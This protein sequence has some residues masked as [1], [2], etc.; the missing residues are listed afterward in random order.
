MSNNGAEKV[1]I[2]TGVTKGFGKEVARELLA[3][4]WAVVGDGRDPEAIQSI[5]TELQ[6]TGPAFTGIAGTITDESHLKDLV[7]A[8]A[9]LGS[10]QLLVNNAGTLG[11]SPLPSVLEVDP[12]ALLEIFRVNVVAAVRLLQVAMRQIPQGQDAAIVNVSSDAAVGFYEGWG[13]YGSSK[14]ALEHLSK[15]FIAEVP[16]VR[17][18]VLDPGDMRTDMHQAA[19]VGEDISDRPLP[20]AKV[21]ALMKLVDGQLPSGRYAAA[22][23]LT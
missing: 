18:Y 11:P 5:I 14:A 9:E 21:P 22:D 6:G 19:F 12:D 23:L 17:M 3:T 1:A 20:A 13:P 7:D 16:S 4:G 15:V 2:V 8:A 10:L